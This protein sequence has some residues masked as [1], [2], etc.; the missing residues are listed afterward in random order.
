MD[1]K[2]LCWVNKANLKILHT[3][4]VHLYKLSKWQNYRDGKHTRGDQELGVV[5]ELG[6]AWEKL[7]GV[8]T[9]LYPV[10]GGSYT[11]IHIR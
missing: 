8:G 4:W 9:V 6:V 11:N 3:T 1:R 7:H 5:G 10:C 2:T